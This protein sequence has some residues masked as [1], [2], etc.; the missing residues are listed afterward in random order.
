MK[1]HN[2]NDSND[3]GKWGEQVLRA[4]LEA[5]PTLRRYQD[6][7][8]VESYRKMDIDAILHFQDG[9]RRK[10]EF[11]TDTYTTG[12]MFFETE[13][14]IEYNTPGCMYKTKAEYLYYYMAAYDKVYIIRM[15]KYRIWFNLH[16]HM[17]KY[18]KFA[19]DKKTCK[20]HSGGY[21]IPMKYLEDHFSEKYWQVCR[22]PRK[23]KK[24]FQA[25]EKIQHLCA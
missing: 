14:C 24:M 22:V 3:V 11:K 10:V 8:D 21:A 20:T 19:N 4:F 1:T 6:V 7:S 12:N 15:D 18:H 16:K 25:P 17:F 9:P 5:D 23:F 13:S 2:F